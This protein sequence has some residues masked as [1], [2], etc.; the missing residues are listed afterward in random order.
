M[1][2][3]FKV[4]RNIEDIE[5]TKKLI[6]L[7]SKLHSSKTFLDMEDDLKLNKRNLNHSNQCYSVANLMQSHKSNAEKVRAELMNNLPI[8]GDDYAR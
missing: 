3:R 6:T 2:N 8:N 1:I 7:K 4:N 5:D